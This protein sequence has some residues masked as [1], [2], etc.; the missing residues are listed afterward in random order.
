MATKVK[1]P[2]VVTVNLSRTVNLGNYE[3]VKL[4]VSLSIPFFDPKKLHEVEALAI[5]EAERF[6]DS[7]IE[8]LITKYSKGTKV[9]D[10]E[11]VLNEEE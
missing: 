7:E 6:I 5:S 2:F 3:S 10:I 1:Q 4:G 9:V 8:R 11:E